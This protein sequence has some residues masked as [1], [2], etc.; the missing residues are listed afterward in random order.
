MFGAELSRLAAEAL[1]LVL[2]VSAPALL[3]S[4]VVGFVVGLLQALTQ[5]Q[6]QTLGF[7]PKL[8]AVAAALAITGGW[9]GSELVRFTE[10]LWLSIPQ[11]FR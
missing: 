5:V 10:T 4:L 1:Y 11:L 7:V 9:M 8:V 2:W 6:D 3:V